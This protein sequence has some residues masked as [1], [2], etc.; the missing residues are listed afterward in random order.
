[1]LIPNLTGNVATAV[2]SGTGWS[3]TFFHNSAEPSTIVK[4][5]TNYTSTFIRGFGALMVGWLMVKITHKWTV[6]L[7]FSMILLAIPAIWVPNYWVFIFLRMGL[8]FGGSMTVI[9][10]QPIKSVLNKKAKSMLTTISTYG[11]SFGAIISLLPF[12]WSEAIN[13]WFTDHWQLIST[14]AA[15]STILVFIGY[16]FIGKNFLPKEKPKKF[17]VIDLKHYTHSETEIQWKVIDLLK[18][19][20]T[21][22]WI[23]LFGL[24]LTMMVMPTILYMHMFAPK[25]TTFYEQR[26]IRI[27]VIISLLG[28]LI[29]PFTIG[30]WLKTSFKRKPYIIFILFIIVFS[31]GLS[32]LFWKLKIIWLFLIMGFIFGWLVQSIQGIITYL[33]HEDPNYKARPKRLVSFYGIIWGFGYWVFTIVNIL[34]SAIYDAVNS[35]SEY[36]VIS[37][38]LLSG[39][40]CVLSVIFIKETKPEGKIWALKKKSIKIHKP[41]D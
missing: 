40:I 4:Q 21:Y 13:L 41:L 35:N 7:S 32:F 28:V 31:L 29:G 20:K 26:W 9:L 30:K 36:V 25:E 37:I 18:E 3:D 16:L 24:F 17:T 38:M 10:L 39:I 14:I 23:I 6:I 15:C 2:K 22:V 5:A 11:F 1:M 12:I 34:I 19:L 8:A 33:P 27:W